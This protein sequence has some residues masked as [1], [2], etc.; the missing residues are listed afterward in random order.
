M[1][2]YRYPTILI[3]GGTPWQKKLA[4]EVIEYCAR[5]L[6]ET[7]HPGMMGELVIDLRLIKDLSKKDN[8][9]ADVI[10]DD[11]EDPP[12]EFLMRLDSSMNEMGLI[13]AICHEMVHV[14]QFASGDLTEGGHR[15]AKWR[16]RF[17]EENSKTYWTL[18]WEVIAYGRENGLLWNFIDAKKYS[19]KKWC[20]DY[21]YDRPK[22]L[23]RGL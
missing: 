18:P 10:T 1:T 12:R 15:K 4:Q 11:D 16:G 20:V 21:D 9:K 7:K 14:E 8:T 2:R 5:V 19:G 22:P 17:F 6:I 23:P 3:R 13:R